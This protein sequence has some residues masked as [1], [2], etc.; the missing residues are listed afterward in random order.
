[1]CVCVRTEAIEC[2]MTLDHVSILSRSLWLYL[3]LLALVKVKKKKKRKRKGKEKSKKRRKNGLF[4]F[5]LFALLFNDHNLSNSIL[6][7]EKKL[8][9]L[10]E[11]KKEGLQTTLFQLAIA[12]KTLAEAQEQKNKI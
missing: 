3:F 1:M 12:I 11:K 9:P 4:S 8:E 2:F 10:N 6:K 5:V 7:R